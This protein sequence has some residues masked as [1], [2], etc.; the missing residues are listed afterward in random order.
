VTVE[1][2][3]ITD[4]DLPDVADFLRA[5]LNDRVP[6][7]RTCS[8]PWTVDAPNH[9]FMIRDG[10]RVVGTL[11][12]LYSQR[13]VSGRPERFCNLGSWC[14]L[15]E[16][17][18]R[19]ISLLNTALAQNGY[20]FTVLSPNTGSEEIL[21]WLK[22]RALDTSAALIPNLPWPTLP[23]GTQISADP[24]VIE[25]ML[26]GTDL[27]IYRDH[28]QALA[29]HHLVLS[30]GGQPC[31]VMYRE[32]RHKSGLVLAVILHVSNPEL[33]HRALMPLT[34]HLLIRHGLVATVAELRIIGRKPTLAF[35]LSRRPKLYRS[36]SL[37]SAQ[38]DDLYSELVCVPM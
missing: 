14:V 23:G 6:W 26:V 27:K 18:A 28:V 29:T 38:I 2:T 33:F 31:H 7:D 12:A 3:A 15:P 35:P 22:F 8:A 9:G 30:R 1:I 21:G 24:A 37:E 32:S 36:A 13:T 34:R 4:A 19:S 5:N 17:R 25:Q 20:H 11:L 16:Y 10:Q